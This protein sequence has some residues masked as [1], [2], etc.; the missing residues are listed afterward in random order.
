MIWILSL[1][2]G[3]IAFANSISQG[4]DLHTQLQ[5]SLLN[6]GLVNENNYQILN[7]FSK[8]YQNKIP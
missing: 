3:Q 7:D 1:V 8:N 5:N 2:I 6:Q 4:S